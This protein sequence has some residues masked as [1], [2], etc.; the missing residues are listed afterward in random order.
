MG[1]TVTAPD[2]VTCGVAVLCGDD[3]PQ[4][5]NESDACPDKVAQGEEV[6]PTGL[7]LTHPDE[8]RDSEANKVTLP[9]PLTEPMPLAE[10]KAPPALFEGNTDPRTPV[11]EACML[12]EGVREGVREISG[13]GVLVKEGERV[14]KTEPDG[15]LEREGMRGVEEDESEAPPTIE[16]E[17]PLEGDGRLVKVT[18]GEGKMEGVDT[19]GV[20]VLVALLQIECLCEGEGVMLTDTRSDTVPMPPLFEEE[21]EMVA[22]R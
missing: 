11:G 15:T 17:A 7:E 19:G 4:E 13:E 14:E 22:S 18:D 12:P 3:V 1:V 21:G 5:L 8:L 10:D 9:V 20:G 2:R 6:A 16:G